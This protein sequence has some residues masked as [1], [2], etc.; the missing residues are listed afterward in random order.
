LLSKKKAVPKEPPTPAK[1]EEPT[2][3]LRITT[4]LTK[5]AMATIQTLQHEHRMRTGKTLPAWKIVSEALELYGKQRKET[6][7]TD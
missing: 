7:K 3:R 1:P 6:T 4:D 5:H 2:S